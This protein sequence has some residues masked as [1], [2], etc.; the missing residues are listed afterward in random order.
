MHKHFRSFLRVKRTL[1]FADRTPMVNSHFAP[2]SRPIFHSPTDRQAGRSLSLPQWGKNRLLR[3]H[4]L[5][6][7][8]SFL[9]DHSEKQNS[10]QHHQQDEKRFVPE[11]HLISGRRQPKL[12]PSPTPYALPW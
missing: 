4:D 3:R 1:S 11:R 5:I 7:G 10:D 2:F 8:C 9:H 12:T 6:I